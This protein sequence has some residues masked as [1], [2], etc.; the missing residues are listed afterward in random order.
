MRLRL[1]TLLGVLGLFVLTVSGGGG[2]D[3]A[4]VT[5]DEQTVKKATIGTDGPSLLKFFQSRTLNENQAERVLTLIQQL[6]S[7]SFI[8]REQASTDLV[9]MGDIAIPLLRRDGITSPDVEIARRST[10]CLELLER[11][12]SN[13]LAAAAARLLAVR[14][15]DATS[16]I[17]LAYLPFADDDLVVEEVSATLAAVALRDGKPDSALLEALDEDQPLRRGVAAEALIRGIK[18]TIPAEVRKLLVDPMP[19]VRMRVALALVEAKDKEAIPVL[20]DLLGELPSTE[21]WKAHEMLFRLARDQAPTLPL[22]DKPEERRKCRDAWNAWWLAHGQELDLT[23]FDLVPRELGLTVVAYLDANNT[24][25]RVAEITKEQKVNW[26]LTGLNYP[27][28]AQVVG[29]DRILVAEHRLN[30]VTER[31]LKGTIIWQHTVNYPVACQRLLNGNTFIACRNQLVEVDANKKALF[32]YNRPNYD[33]VSAR[34]SRNGEYVFV[35][36]NGLYIRL[37]ARGQEVKSFPIGRV[38][39]YSTIDMTPTG[40]VIIPLTSENRV[41]EYDGEGRLLWSVD[42]QFPTSAM[43]LPSGNTLLS[44]M[45]TQRVVEINRRGQVVWE[46]K[47]PGRPLHA[48][49]R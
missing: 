21:S 23:D 17:L 7:D 39:N 34:K 18:G 48:F 25:G 49:R 28:D 13:L 32:T 38:Q 22:G 2:A 14:Q 4:Q 11:N 31:D 20:I 3:P 8:Q 24:T 27:V 1:S 41:V 30:R 26:Q 6:G 47:P 36:T 40:H 42:F 5:A 16:E 37:N 19:E 33:I 9:K 46:H 45:N 12:P 29:K 44:S 35:T 10:Q 43:R 15:P